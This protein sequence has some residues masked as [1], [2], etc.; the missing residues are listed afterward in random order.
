MLS[1]STILARLLADL[2]PC[3]FLLPGGRG[4]LR[5][6]QRLVFSVSCP[7]SQWSHADCFVL[8][9]PCVLRRCR[10]DQPARP[11]CLNPEPPHP[12]WPAAADLPTIP[13]IFKVSP[14]RR[15]CD[16]LSSSSASRFPQC[17][18]HVAATP[19]ILKPWWWQGQ[20]NI[21]CWH[22]LHRGSQLPISVP[23]VPLIIS[24]HLTLL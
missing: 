5:Y 12:T 14:S 18:V 19:Q 1:G 21:T 17:G 9:R 6:M 10:C 16:I 3:V 15:G 4:S 23:N 22:A 8:R 7:L 2:L 20:G 13:Y 11:C 24:N